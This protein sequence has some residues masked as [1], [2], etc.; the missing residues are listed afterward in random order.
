MEKK[1]KNQ[2]WPRLQQLSAPPDA[3]ESHIPQYPTSS[4][5]KKDW[6]KLEREIVNEAKKNKDDDEGA[7]GLFK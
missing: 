3:E 4:T 1:I 6:A 7:N 2:L 5:K